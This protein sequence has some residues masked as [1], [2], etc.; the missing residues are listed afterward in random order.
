M[1]VR[2]HYRPLLGEL[3]GRAPVPL[4]GL[5]DGVEAVT[6]P[7]RRNG[8]SRVPRDRRRR[9]NPARVDLVADT[10]TPLFEPPNNLSGVALLE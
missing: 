2:E 3:A 9:V 1:T 4:V 10:R 7:T 6:V 8:E 5:P